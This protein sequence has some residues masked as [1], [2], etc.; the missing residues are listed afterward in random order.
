MRILSWLFRSPRFAVVTL[1]L[2]WVFVVFWC[3][4]HHP[5]PESPGREVL[6]PALQRDLDEVYRDNTRAV[7]AFQDRTRALGWPADHVR[8]GH[9]TLG[10]EF[11]RRLRSVYRRHGQEPPASLAD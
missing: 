8:V 10:G 2:L 6:P 5:H 3:N 4:Y 7:D 11:R 9:D 1:L